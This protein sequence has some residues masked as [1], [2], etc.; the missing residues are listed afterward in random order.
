V[1]LAWILNQSFPSIAVVPLPYLL[2]ARRSEY[3]HASEIVLG[4]AAR[5]WLSGAGEGAPPY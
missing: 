1:N 5:E 3:E 2:A 4:G